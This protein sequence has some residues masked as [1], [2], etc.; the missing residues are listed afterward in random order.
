MAP[1]HYSNSRF[2]CIIGGGPAGMMAA[3]AAARAGARVRLFDRMHRVGKKLLVT[4]NAR[5]NLT[6][7]A[8]GPVHYHGGDPDFV[9]QALLKLGPAQTRAFFEELGILTKVEDGGKVFPLC[10]Q[11]SAVLDVLRYEMRRLGVEE[12][13]DTRIRAI[14]KRGGS[15]GGFVLCG[16]DEMRIE[17]DRV[18]LAAGGKAVPNLGS[19]G[20]GFDLAR[21]LGHTIV[22]PFPALVQIT[23]DAPF[24]KH[25]K[26]VRI[27][28]AARLV[29][30]NRPTP[31]LR[32]E[33]LMTDYGATGIPILQLSRLVGENA[34]EGSERGEAHAAEPEK[35]GG[36]PAHAAKPEK[37]GGAPAQAAKSQR[38]PAH[39]A[40]APQPPAH[41]AKPHAPLSLEIDI[42]PDIKEADLQSLLMERFC[43][44]PDRSLEF[45]LVGLIHKRLLAVSLKAAGIADAGQPCGGVEWREAGLIAGAI[46]RWRIPVSGT[47]S[48]MH[49]QVT[50]GGVSTAE[51]DPATMA[52]RLAPGL[53]FA[54][55]VIDVDGD[56]GGYNLQWAWSSG[57]LAGASAAGKPD[58]VKPDTG[59]SNAGEGE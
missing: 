19:N 45:S 53:F 23:L 3:I 27:Q 30:G 33:I 46:K 16:P 22:E 42:L 29:I 36:A 51:I 39:F 41:A 20:S 17:C 12:L 5:C 58:T 8:C 40:Q 32:D 57:H 2:I 26:G 7:V 25:L 28:G 37:P 6:N 11:A 1:V 24:L 52:S 43:A 49:A 21:Q 54:G 38:E 55:E 31:Y 59:K 14:E 15:R 34:M 9:R 56:C 47:Q 35:P 50:A 48:W 4:G 44:H 18:V 10:G 13:C